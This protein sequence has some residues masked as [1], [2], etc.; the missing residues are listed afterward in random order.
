[1]NIVVCVKQVTDTEVERSLVPGDNTV[2]VGDLFPV[3][4][5]HRRD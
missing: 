4:A 2:V 5:A 1:M 3:P